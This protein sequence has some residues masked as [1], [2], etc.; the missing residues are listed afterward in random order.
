MIPSFLTDLQLPQVFSTYTQTVDSYLLHSTSDEHIVD[1]ETKHISGFVTPTFGQLEEQSAKYFEVVNPTSR[2]YSLLQIDNGLVDTS[3]T[4]KCDCA[5]ANDTHFCFIEF[6]ANA[7]SEKADTIEKNYKKAIKQIEVTR[8]IFNSHYNT[9]G[10]DIM[11]I[12][13]VEAYICF[14][15]GY[16]RKTSTQI[17]YQV[18]FAENNNGMPLSFRRKKIL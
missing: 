3:S 12:R 16:P 8:D 9:Q 18:S 13:K 14:R 17:N 1:S 2:P 15:H 11:S 10:T 4:P 5:I 7:T 6:K